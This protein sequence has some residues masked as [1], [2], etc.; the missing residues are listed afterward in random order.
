MIYSLFLAVAA[1]NLK[2]DQTLVGTAMNMLAPALV[3]FLVRIIANQNTLQME[4]GDSASWF[5][6]K[7][8]ML[9]FWKIILTALIR[10]NLLIR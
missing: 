6:I 1:I 8:T 5:M 7:K 2:A 10:L 3:L 4:T 9:G